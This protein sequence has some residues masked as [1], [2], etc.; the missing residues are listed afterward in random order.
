MEQHTAAEI[1]SLCRG[2]KAGID[3]LGNL[4]LSGNSDSV[5]LHVSTQCPIL[6]QAERLGKNK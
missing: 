6:P 4:V 3:L 2:V 1:V 5:Q